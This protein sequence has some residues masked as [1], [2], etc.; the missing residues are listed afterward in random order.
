MKRLLLVTLSGLTGAAFLA[1]FQ[2]CS[3]LGGPPGD[4]Q[5]VS[6]ASGLKVVLTWT[7]PRENIPDK[8][9]V[10]FAPLSDT[11]LRQI[12]ETT[13]TTYIHNPH[14]TTGTYVVAAVFGAK[15]YRSDSLLTLPVYSDTLAVAELDASGN[16]AYGWNPRSGAGRTCSMHE[17]GNTRLADFFVTD[18]RVGSNRLPYALASPNM[19]PADPSGLVPASDQWRKSG[20]TDPLGSEYAALPA[21]AETT[22]HNWTDLVSLP[23]IIGCRTQDGHFALVK[24]T[25]VDAGAGEVR[26]ISWFQ[27]VPGLRLVM[28]PAD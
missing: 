2:S 16:D 20:F 21:W 24:V 26:L 3:R 27:R 17:L 1:L 19:G 7:A 18:F 12:A 23:A 25:K 6:D 22:Y 11:N 15:E 8:Y 9:R 4:V 14:D 5:I 10:Y 13:A 28:H